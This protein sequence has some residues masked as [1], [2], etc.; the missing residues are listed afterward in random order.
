MKKFFKT[1]NI[2]KKLFSTLLLLV[3]VPVLFLGTFL[4][5]RTNRSM[6]KQYTDQ[7]KMENA[8][9][10]AIFFDLTTNIYNISEIFVYDTVLTDMLS[11]EYTNEDTLRQNINAYS[12][13]TTTLAQQTSLQN[14]NIYTNNASITDH[15]HFLYCGP[16][17]RQTEWY[18]FFSNNE[19]C[20]WRVVPHTDVGSSFSNLALYRKIPLPQAND[21][22]VLEVTVS[23]N[24]L[25][26]RLNN[27]AIFNCASINEELFFY[28]SDD[29]DEI[30]FPKSEA[31]PEFFQYSGKL[32][33]NGTNCISAIS[34][35]QPYRSDDSLYI[36]SYSD[37]AVRDIA[38]LTWS[39]FLL[40]VFVLLIPCF[41]LYF[42]TQY[43]SARIELLR[44]AMHQ[45]SLG[46][47]NI[48]SSF[49]GNDELSETF[50]DLIIMVRRIEEKESHIYEGRLRE[51]KL[52]SQRQ[53]LEN[54]QHQMEYKMLASQINPHFLYNTLETIRMKAFN[55]DDRE[56]AN[57]IKLLGRYMRYA[58][59]NTG[60]T[61][62][63]LERE[64][65]YL[66]LYLKIQ[67]IRFKNRINYK[68]IIEEKLSPSSIS[69][70]P[71]LLQPVVEN[72]ILHGF[73]SRE[74]GG[75]IEI[76]ISSSSEELLTLRVSDN[77]EGMT[78]KELDTLLE[79]I[80]T[81]D[82]QKTKSIGLYNINQRIHLYYGYEYGI[83]IVSKKGEG[84]SVTI[85]LPLQNGGGNDESTDC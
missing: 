24:Y 26:S 59:E 22:A 2:Q 29:P 54:R 57:A 25:R 37:T 58:L 80:Q 62:T 56:A 75:M 8:R 79:N 55:A 72:A 84:T 41:L 68:I 20:L 71:F 78:E 34:T 50:N 65:D 63:T 38:R 83:V 21:F 47:H 60:T 40:L 6:T 76:N 45:V 73:E 39:Y 32:E 51:Q 46:N 17:I 44:N 15:N 49:K 28:S 30:V 74:S 69:V 27:T 85:D 18:E 19:G 1:V 36:L 10:K 31:T 61:A 16:Q 70:L 43:F 13:V 12:L 64:L 14:I 52:I 82:E 5:I 81:K 67:K 42:Y 7:V 66:E 3:S 77:G 53:E 23:N 9:A 4:L 48:V 35:L 33:I 11:Q